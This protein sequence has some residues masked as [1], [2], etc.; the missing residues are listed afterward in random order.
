M[1]KKGA[2]RPLS[3]L[4][5]IRGFTLVELLITVVIV[6]VIAAIALPMYTRYVATARQ[7]D[8]K[9]QL[10]AVR[11]A[12]EIYKLQ[13]GGYTNDTSLLSGWQSTLGK[14][15]F[16]ITSATATLFTAQA[17]GNIDSD[18]TL[19]VWTINES[20]SLLNTTNDVQS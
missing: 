17:S 5:R 16:S 7:Q 20:G 2:S 3:S 1:L 19:D 6:G 9:A 15:T 14:Y 4:N 11:Q 13:Y 12:Q 10:T 18:A 8:A